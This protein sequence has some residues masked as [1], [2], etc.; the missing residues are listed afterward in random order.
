MRFEELQNFAILLKALRMD[1]RIQ[2]LGHSNGGLASYLD[3]PHKFNIVAPTIL[4][5]LASLIEVPDWLKLAVGR[6]RKI[7]D[8]L[9]R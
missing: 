2:F 9:P 4:E 5:S 6:I 1:A 7:Q 8:H 3:K